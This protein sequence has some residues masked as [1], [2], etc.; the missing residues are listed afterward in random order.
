MSCRG[1]G[2]L[3]HALGAER[4]FIKYD[5]E[6]RQLGSVKFFFKFISNTCQSN[7]E[8]MLW[9]KSYFQ[10]AVNFIVSFDEENCRTTAQL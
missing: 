5:K 3:V 6:T 1:F 10:I 9:P 4:C 8:V 2:S 7:G